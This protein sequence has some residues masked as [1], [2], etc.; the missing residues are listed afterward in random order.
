MIR[1]NRAGRG[2]HGIGKSGVWLDD[3]RL[4][5]DAGFSAWLDDDTIAFQ[6]AKDAIAQC[7]VWGGL[8]TDLSPRGAAPLFARAGEWAAYLADG[9]RTSWDLS[10]PAAFP[11]G[12]DADGVLYVIP[13]FQA[14]PGG[15]AAYRRGTFS[16]AWTDLSAAPQ[17]GHFDC[18]PGGR[19][20]WVDG[21]NRLQTS[22]LPAPAQ[23]EDWSSA[24]A[25]VDA[26][27]DGIWLLETTNPGRTALHPLSDASRG[28]VVAENNAFGAAAWCPAPGVVEVVYAG[29]TGEAGPLTRARFTLADA[30]PFPP[31]PVHVDR[32]APRLV[33]LFNPLSMRYGVRLAPVIGNCAVQLNELDGENRSIPGAPELAAALDLPLVVDLTTLP[34]ASRPMAIWHSDTT[35]AGVVAQLHARAEVRPDLRRLLYVDD[36][37]GWTN[38]PPTVLA[39]HLLAF[40]AYCPVGGDLNIFGREVIDVLKAMRA[41]FGDAQ[42]IAIVA[43]AWDRRQ[44]EGSPRETASRL[45]AIAELLVSIARGFACHLLGFHATRPGGVVVHARLADYWQALTAATSLPGWVTAPA[46]VTPEPEEPRPGPRPVPVPATPVPTPSSAPALAPVFLFPRSHA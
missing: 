15:L 41:R 5:A 38:N 33:G 11:L 2:V 30:Q 24:P 20:V 31:A 8:G 22:G 36:L 37:H 3:A 26:G 25:L 19:C 43:Q 34:H 21:Q 27:P 32:L 46:P 40:P 7:D 23:L 14:R 45:L 13:N 6:D 35:A 29:N 1:L 28:F 18:L 4:F 10:L 44:G 16:P 39:R 17:A 12:F 9:V 42:E